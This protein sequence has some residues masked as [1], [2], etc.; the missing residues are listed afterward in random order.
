M[1]EGAAVLF[2]NDA[3]YIAFAGRDMVA[4]DDV[5][6][7]SDQVTCVHPGWSV[8][9]GRDAVMQSWRA[10]LGNPDSPRISCVQPRAFVLGTTAYVLCYERIDGTFLIA[11]NV[12]VREQRSWKL[13]HHQAGTAPP[14]TIEEERSLVQ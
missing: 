8:L 7:A 4:M 1:T 6:A 9:I 11:T 5:W 14:P 13:L 10:I 3:F 12:F 2:C